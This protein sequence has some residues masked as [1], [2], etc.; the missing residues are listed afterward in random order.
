M[1]AELIVAALAREPN[2]YALVRTAAKAARMLHRPKTRIPDTI[3]DAFR[4]LALPR[5]KAPASQIPRQQ[6]P[7]SNA[8]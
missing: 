8:A 3:N 2:R 6:M 1:R 4:F 7:R 5:K